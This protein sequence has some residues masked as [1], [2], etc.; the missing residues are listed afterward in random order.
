M[1]NQYTPG[2]RITVRGEDFM[3]TAVTENYDTSLI[4]D[5]EGISELVKGKSFRFDTNIDD[6]RNQL[7]IAILILYVKCFND[8]MSTV[9]AERKYVPLLLSLIIN[10]Q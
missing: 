7:Y 1:T 9:E 6:D 4:L 8:C 5:T 10:N 3:V 2:A